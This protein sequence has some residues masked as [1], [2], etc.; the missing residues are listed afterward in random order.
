MSDEA[1]KSVSMLDVVVFLAEVA[2]LAGFGVAGAHLGASTAISVLL[3][4]ALPVAAAIIWGRWLA[5]RAAR[6]LSYPG[7]LAVKLLLVLVAA[8][9]LA[10]SGA[11]ILGIGCLLVLGS[12]FTLGEAGG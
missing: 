7:S 5:P 1:R 8:G 12:V 10:L 6:P 2:M 4:I 3:A 11:L 9:L